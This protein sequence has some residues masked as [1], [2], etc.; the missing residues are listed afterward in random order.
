M[1]WA[2]K[3]DLLHQGPTIGGDAPPGGTVEDFLDA[4]GIDLPEPATGDKR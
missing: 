2:G 3:G 4:L 1:T